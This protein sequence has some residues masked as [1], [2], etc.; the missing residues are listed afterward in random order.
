MRRI[1]R[2]F[3]IAVIFFLFLLI[4]CACRGGKTH[5]LGGLEGLWVNRETGEAYRLTKEGYFQTG[6]L[7]ESTNIF[8]VE[9]EQIYLV[10]DKQVVIYEVDQTDTCTDDWLEIG[11]FFKV[12]GTKVEPKD[13]YVEY[14]NRYKTDLSDLTIRPDLDQ[15]K[16]HMNGVTTF[17]AAKS[18]STP[19]K[20]KATNIPKPIASPAPTKTPMILI[21][22]LCRE[23]SA[24]Q[25][26]GMLY[27]PPMIMLF[28]DGLAYFGQE[29]MTEDEMVQIAKSDSVWHGGTPY[30]ITET[31][32]SFALPGGG[33]IDA[34]RE[35]NSIWF[36]N[37]EYACS[38]GVITQ[39]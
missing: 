13:G 5:K 1:T 27:T 3:S 30:T 7:D 34:R 17:N 25:Q 11:G 19:A 38:E 16:T 26:T 22:G 29:G 14:K 35:G 24:G 10:R 6:K 33:S 8:T 15:V 18:D 23:K 36:N 37:A 9:K 12:N 20:T 4:L 28:K 21:N 2:Y 39:K 32:I 31:M